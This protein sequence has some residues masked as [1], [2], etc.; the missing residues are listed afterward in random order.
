M[1]TRLFCISFGLLLALIPTQDKPAIAAPSGMASAA[2]AAQ[3]NLDDARAFQA[4]FPGKLSEL[5]VDE[6]LRRLN[7]VIA[8]PTSAIH[9]Q[10]T[11]APVTVNEFEPNDSPSTPNF[12][13]LRTRYV[14]V[15]GAIGTAGDVDYFYFTA[16]AGARIWILV[17]TG[18]TQ[19]VSA[20]SRDTEVELLAA[21]G[22]TVIESD[23]DDGTGN[24]GDATVEAGLSSAIAGRLLPVSGAYYVRVHGFNSSDIINPYQLFIAL[25]TD[26]QVSEVEPNNSVGLADP[27]QAPIGTRSGVIGTGGDIDYFSF[28][29]NFGDIA[30]VALDADPERDGS[31]FNA[32][33]EFRDGS[34]ALIM[35]I[36]SSTLGSILDP[37][38]E[39]FR[40]NITTGGNYYVVVKGFAG[41]DIG[42][43]RLMVAISPAA[44]IRAE[45]ESN[46]TPDLADYLEVAGNYAEGRGAI[47]AAD[48]D[49]WIFYLPTTSFVW[50]STDVRQ[51]D[52]A[53]SDTKIDL[54]AS[55][56]V[57]LIESDDDDGSC[58]DRGGT[59]YSGS[60]S[61]IAG[62]LLLPGTYY[63]RVQGYDATTVINR[64]RLY[65][66]RTIIAATPEVEFNNS[67]GAADFLTDTIGVRFGDL[68]PAGDVDYFR[69]DAK[70]G[71][72]I[73]FMADG[74]FGADTDL[75][76]ELRNSSG[77]VLL[78]IDSS[79][80]VNRV[81]EGAQ[82]A[83]PLN[84]RITYD[85]YVVVRN[86][87]TTSTAGSYKLMGY[88]L[89]GGDR[90]H[91]SG[92]E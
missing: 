14:Q 92:F 68:N 10:P 29:A 31:T 8:P 88:V 1:N 20:T 63:V 26:E 65:L 32:V 40:F 90:I 81:A 56:G 45:A 37:P 76:L 21:D 71:D 38:A 51:V 79:G 2:T 67:I 33:L 59:V 53:D 77:S 86:F 47:T 24:G 70:G 80:I 49:Y 43:Y 39:A 11:G 18:G 6:A 66:A 36:D 41:T 89:P 19:D 13:S 23:D 69:I 82:Y 34:G 58:N 87:N 85:Y 62:T 52:L 28:R 72:V 42:N 5:G 4:Q 54:L 22:T 78:N 9:F 25:S 16:P 74:S 73:Y 27:I 55:D 7:A 84:E 83:I 3:R 75:V 61:A 17:D 60:C 12:L 64:Y 91:R 35:T 15:N 50:I 46:N 44:D 57:T 48:V 30:F